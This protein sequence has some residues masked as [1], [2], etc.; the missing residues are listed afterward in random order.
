MTIPSDSLDSKHA[1]QQQQQ[2]K[3]D[4]ASPSLPPGTRVCVCC[5]ESG[6]N[7]SV[8]S[9]IDGQA[10][11]KMLLKWTPLPAAPVPLQPIINISLP[12]TQCLKGYALVSANDFEQRDPATWWVGVF[13]YRLFF[14]DMWSFSLVSPFLFA[15]LSAQCY[16]PSSTSF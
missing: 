16:H 3:P 4:T 6:R 13:S 14:V 11:T 8:A 7:E 10:A 12:S 9:L 1:I 5:S 15:V 2:Q